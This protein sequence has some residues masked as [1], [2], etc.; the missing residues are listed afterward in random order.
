MG[1]GGS[2]GGLRGVSAIHATPSDQGLR[3]ANS[4]ELNSERRAGVIQFVERCKGCDKLTLN[5]ECGTR[6]D[7]AAPPW[8]IAGMTYEEWRDSERVT[9]QGTATDEM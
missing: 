9:A 1:S 8:R 3:D 7:S 6:E 4:K 5:C 2:Q